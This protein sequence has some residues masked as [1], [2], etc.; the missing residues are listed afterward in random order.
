ML[1]TT[2]PLRRLAFPPLFFSE[3]DGFSDEVDEPGFSDDDDEP[4]PV[5]GVTV[6]VVLPGVVVVVS[7]RG[8]S[9]RV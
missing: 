8:A 4:G 9:P 7:S 5:G 1:K 6:G 3:D 2:K